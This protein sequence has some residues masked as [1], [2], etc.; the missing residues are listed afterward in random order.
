MKRKTLKPTNLMQTLSHRH[1][2]LSK[3]QKQLED[4][5]HRA[6]DGKIHIVRGNGRVQY[7][8]R[9]NAKDKSGRYI[10]MN[11]TK[12]LKM[13]LQK[14][15]DMKL[16]P[17]IEKEIALIEKLQNSYGEND[18]KLQALYESFPEKSRPYIDPVALTDEAFAHLWSSEPFEG[19]ELPPNS[20]MF[21]T[22]R[23]EHVRS[24]SELAIAN[25]L[26]KLDIPYKYECPLHLNKYT[27][28]HPDFTVLNKRTREVFYWEHRGMM[29]DRDYARHAVTRLKNY[30]EAD[31]LPGKNLIITEETLNC[32]LSTVEIQNVI[33]KF[34]I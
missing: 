19:K 22:D 13:Y 31:I 24:K 32:P 23:E 34:L 15:Y 11:D 27:V 28:I 10:S 21:V 1:E 14:S 8:L 4:A 30:G 5:I 12:K 6:A 7:Y 33:K 20:P 18:K 26:N 9:K 17:L 25:A 3:C 29:D 2:E 16:L